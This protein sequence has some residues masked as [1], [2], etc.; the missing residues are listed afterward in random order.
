MNQMI[1]AEGSQREQRGK[2]WLYGEVWHCGGR[3]AV[4]VRGSDNVQK[5]LLQS[6][7]GCYTTKGQTNKIVNFYPREAEPCC[8]ESSPRC[9]ERGHEHH[10]VSQYF[11]ISELT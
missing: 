3:D 5:A 8:E 4:T 10:L 6:F 7:P 11:D 9:R 1:A 2:L